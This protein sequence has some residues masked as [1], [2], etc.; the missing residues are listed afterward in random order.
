MLGQL[1]KTNMDRVFDTLDVTSDGHL[2]ADDFQALAQRMRNL[3]PNMD[4]ELA[5]EIDDAFT[6]WWEHFRKAADTDG[7]GRISREEFISA[8]DH[9]LQNDP[10]YAD[11]MVK[12]SQ[13][14]FRAAD[15]EGDGYLTPQQVTRIYEAYGVDA[16]HS[17]ETVARLDRDSDGRISVDEFV[18]AARE[19]YLSNDPTAPGVVMFGPVA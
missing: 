18:Q 14:T 9:G 10:A 6:S 16:Q 4:A 15:A 8:V 17:K 7:D 12:V 5:A 2:S 3:R 19:V 1:Q 13:V 11:R